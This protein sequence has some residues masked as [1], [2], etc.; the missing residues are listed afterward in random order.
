MQAHYLDYN[1]REQLKIKGENV[2]KTVECS[3]RR[4]KIKRQIKILYLK[5]MLAAKT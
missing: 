1:G 5:L 4:F 3:G 2:S